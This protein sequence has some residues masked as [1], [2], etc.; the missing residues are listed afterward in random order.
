M[1]NSNDR[2][3]PSPEQ[4]HTQRT[5]QFTGLFL[6]RLGLIIAGSTG[7]YRITRHLLRFVELPV[8]VEIGAGLLI[9]GLVLFLASFIMERIVDARQERSIKP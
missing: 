9:A 6:W 2:D 4:S 5:I 1:L 3:R 8:Q 7:V